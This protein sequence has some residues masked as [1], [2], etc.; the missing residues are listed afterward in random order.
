MPA[1]TTDR[2]AFRNLDSENEFDRPP[3]SKLAIASLMVGVVSLVSPIHFYLLPISLLAIGLAALVLWK[4]SRD[5]AL[6]GIYLAQAGLGLGF[7]SSAWCL[8]ASLGTAAYLHH[9]AARN[10]KIYLEL[11]SKGDVYQALELHVPQQNRQ[12]AGTDLASYYLAR[13][14]EK[15]EQS[16]EILESDATKAVVMSGRE[17]EW[18][19]HRGLDI[20][21]DR[22][23]QKVFIQM[24]NAAKP[25]QIVNVVLTRRHLVDDTGQRLA[26]WN[27]ENISLPR[28]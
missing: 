21:S 13:T 19:Y 5:K 1:A 4:L 15:D 10:A 18:E 12:I 14:G 16:Q 28:A 7:I 3:I 6:G 23:V 20:R 9:E 24:R 27:I 25:S 17:A 26:F 22:N 2:P 11:L 8:T